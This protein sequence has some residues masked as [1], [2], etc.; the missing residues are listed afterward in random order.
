MQIDTSTAALMVYILIGVLISIRMRRS[1]IEAFSLTLHEQIKF[2]VATTAFYWFMIF[3]ISWFG[4]PEYR[5][6]E[7]WYDWVW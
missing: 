4:L 5:T 2:F 1:F 7:E 6:Y 3:P